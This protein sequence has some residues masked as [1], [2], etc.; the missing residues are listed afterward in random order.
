M[1][2]RKKQRDVRGTDLIRQINPDFKSADEMMAELNAGNLT[3]LGDAEHGAYCVPFGQEV[4]L[5]EFADKSPLSFWQDHLPEWHPDIC[6]LIHNKKM[7]GPRDTR[8]VDLAK[9]FNSVKASLTKLDREEVVSKKA[10]LLF[11]M[12]AIISVF[13]TIGSIGFLALS[14]WTAVVVSVLAGGV[15]ILACWALYIRS[16]EPVYAAGRSLKSRYS[17]DIDNLWYVKSA[18]DVRSMVS[19][20]EFCEERDIDATDLAMRVDNTIRDCVTGHDLSEWRACGMGAKEDL[21]RFMGLTRAITFLQS[22]G[23]SV[24]RDT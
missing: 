1:F 8:F 10:R 21:W 2:K 23:K 22:Q 7:C 3:S 4:L 13:A 19:I 6:D 24:S 5:D 18:D 12:L 20:I 15:A 17:K 14:F 11:V 9:E 16:T